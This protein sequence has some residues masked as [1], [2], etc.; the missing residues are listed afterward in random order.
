MIQLLSISD[1][2][3]DEIVISAESSLE[4]SYTDMVDVCMNFSVVGSTK[5]T[6][7]VLT[8]LVKW[9]CCTKMQGFR[10][11]N[12]EMFGIIRIDQ[13]KKGMFL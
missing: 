13:D 12:G 11:T 3:A 6:A 4:Y 10:F 8:D 2:G 9:D 7:T 1:F 5:Y